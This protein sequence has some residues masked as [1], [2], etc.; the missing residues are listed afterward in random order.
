MKKVLLLLLVLF[1]AGG[2]AFSAD[3]MNFPP[4]L[5][6]GNILIDVGLGFALAPKKDTSMKVP[7]IVLS[8][9]YC[10]PSGVPISVGGLIG[11]YQYEYRYKDPGAHV[12]WVETLTF[13]TFGA[14]ANWHWNIDIGIDWIDLYTGIF[15]GYTNF[16][17]SSNSSPYSGYVQ[18]AHGGLNFGGQAG[19][20]L[21]FTNRFGAVVELGY[22]FVA[23]AGLAIKF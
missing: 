7:P 21:Y 13:L 11:F 4:S 14:R 22:P 19:A 6:G 3:L 5:D 12:P 8:A 2:L 1:V 20:H 16:S 9:E 17:W 15:F 18:D 23:K 10:L